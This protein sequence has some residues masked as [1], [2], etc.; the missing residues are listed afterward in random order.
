VAHLTQST[1]A[2]ARP[3]QEIAVCWLIGAMSVLVG[4]VFV[5]VM[6]IMA[7]LLT[8]GLLGWSVV[9]ALGRRR[10]LLPLAVGVGLTI[11]VVVYFSLAIAQH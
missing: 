4:F 1:K 8:V 2:R 6:P 9:S 5:V 7:L 3:E 10:R 11:P